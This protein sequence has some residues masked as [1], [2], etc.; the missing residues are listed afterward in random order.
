MFNE[1]ATRLLDQIARELSGA[2]VIFPTSFDLTLRVQA[3][4]K[5][6]DTTIDKIAELVRAEPL[7]ST[8]VLAYANSASVRGIGPEI[9]DVGRAILRIG[10]D[11]V[12]TVS[13]TLAVEQIIRSKHMQPFQSL[14][15]A[16]W[17]HSLAVAAIARILA[18]RQR[19]NPEKAFFMGMIHDIGAFYLL[20]RCSQDTILAGNRDELVELVY[21]WHDGIGHALLSAMG[22]P[23][24]VLTAVQDHEAP[25]TV[26]SLS[27]WTA[28]LTS[29][30]C[31]GQQIIDW[32]PEPM[33]AISPRTISEKVISA[34]DQAAILAQAKEDLT[35]LRAALF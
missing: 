16:I 12:R 20:F 7:M 24:D 23:E 3:L 22:Q 34:E 30:D 8:K 32:V 9:T 15:N 6:P 31:L 28:I 14:S 5:N 27:N 19:M 35:S 13:Y 21:Q 18:T 4:L 29:S 26:G 25:T 1:V 33:R 11:A 2:D 17:E 10:L